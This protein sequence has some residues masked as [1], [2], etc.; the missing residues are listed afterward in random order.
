[1]SDSEMAGWQHAIHALYERRRVPTEVGTESRTKQSMADEQ[2]VNSI[3]RKYLSTGQFPVGNTPSR[4]GDFSG[5]ED[6][7]T[8]LNR[9]IETQRRFDLLPAHVRS[10][11][12]N[13]PGELLDLVNDPARLEEARK[14]GLLEP[15][16]EP[17][18]PPSEPVP[19]E[20]APAPEPGPNS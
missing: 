1:M 7:H 14:L 13:D 8:V 10:H 5:L 11:V 12:H 18:A 17:E 4:Y 9:V 19:T 6:Y 20:P 15:V 16:P 3:M 2:D